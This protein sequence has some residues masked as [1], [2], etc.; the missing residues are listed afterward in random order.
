MFNEKTKKGNF[1]GINWSLMKKVKK[2]I[3]VVLMF[4]KKNLKKGNFRRIN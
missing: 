2:E 1:R 3:S 4:N